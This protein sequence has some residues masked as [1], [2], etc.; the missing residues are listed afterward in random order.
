MEQTP[1]IEQ[2]IKEKEELERKLNLLQS[3]VIAKDSVK[4]DTIKSNLDP[5][6][7]AVYYRYRF[8]KRVGVYAA[9]RFAEK[10]VP[11]IQGESFDE[12]IDGIPD[13]INELQS[14][15]ETVKGVEHG[16]DS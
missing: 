10:W 16:A 3:M 1:T 4:I 11:F 14:F 12:V 2:L 13:V 7:W 5:G 8:I 9:K 15:Y 6:K